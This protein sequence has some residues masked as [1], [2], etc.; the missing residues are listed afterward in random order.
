MLRKASVRVTASLRH[1]AQS[2]LRKTA[3]RLTLVEMS[4]IL[5][6]EIHGPSCRLPAVA[7]HPS[8]PNPSEFQPGPARS[9]AVPCGP[10]ENRAGS[11]GWAA[12]AAVA[13][14]RNLDWDG[15]AGKWEGEVEPI[16][17]DGAVVAAARAAAGAVCVGSAGLPAVGLGARA[18]PARS[19][20]PPPPR[21]R[22]ARGPAVTNRRSPSSL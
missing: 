8:Y 13:V 6:N 19:C 16:R 2:C 12:V 5:I 7:R 4:Y 20:N 18:Q 11:T 3:C 17:A 21:A 9:W 10:A 22:A 15:R 1:E 14:G